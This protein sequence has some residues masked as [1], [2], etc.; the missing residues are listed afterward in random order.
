MN[1]KGGAKV[2]LS[3]PS[4]DAPKVSIAGYSAVISMKHEK[5][6]NFLRIVSNVSC[7][8]NH[9]APLAMVMDDDFGIVQVFMTIVCAFTDTQKIMDFWP[10]WA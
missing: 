3:T 1:F 9:L 2:F 4:A 7:T 6:D 10:L 8:T 5:Y